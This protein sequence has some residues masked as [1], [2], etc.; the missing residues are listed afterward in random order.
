MSVHRPNRRN[1]RIAGIILMT[2]ALL[3]FGFAFFPT[4]YRTETILIPAGELPA[5]Y[6]L[7]VRYPSF[8]QADAQA[9][10]TA[11]LRPSVEDASDAIQGIIVAE[12]QSA[13]IRFSPSGRILA[14]LPAGHRVSFSWTATGSR[15][16][17][18]SFSL[19]LFHQNA[20]ERDVNAAGLPV[21]ARSFTWRTFTGLGVMKPPLLVCAALVFLI[22]FGLMLANMPRRQNFQRP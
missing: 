1:P 4:I 5:D 15:A 12:A 11:L 7:E 13:D 2:A 16:G 20:Q 14:P 18:R 19:F 21:W 8:G 22:G 9:N 3:L 17:N 10:V 6:Q